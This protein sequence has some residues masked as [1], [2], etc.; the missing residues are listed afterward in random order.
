[1]DSSLASRL[2]QLA[3]DNG[4][5]MILHDGYTSTRCGMPATSAVVCSYS[6]FWIVVSLYCLYSRGGPYGI[7]DGITYEHLNTAE[8]TRVYY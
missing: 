2:V 8:G 1:M 6:T 3:K 7:L 5:T 4:M